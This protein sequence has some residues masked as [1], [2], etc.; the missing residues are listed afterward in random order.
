MN[1]LQAFPAEQ[2]M[3]LCKCIANPPNY[4]NLKFKITPSDSG[5]FSQH[6]RVSF[7][8]TTIYNMCTQ[9]PPYDHSE[10]LYIRY[11]N[12]F[13]TYIAECILPS[14]FDL[15]GERLLKALVK[16]WNSHKIMIRWLMRFFNYLDRYYVP[17]HNLPTLF[18]VGLLV[19]R[20]RFYSRCLFRFY[21]CFELPILTMSSCKIKQHEWMQIPCT[22]K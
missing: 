11:R 19:F 22:R 17:R 18:N 16:R 3:M 7:A 21:F 4:F 10:Q 13:E 1:L 15:Q 5:G 2:Q 12:A 8:D 14:L 20:G 6:C 9:K